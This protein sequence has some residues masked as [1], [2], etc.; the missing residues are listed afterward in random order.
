MRNVFTRLIATQPESD[1]HR[2]EDDEPVVS[3]ETLHLVAA[4]S[5]RVTAD[6]E[7]QRAEQRERFRDRVVRE[8]GD[9][10]AVVERLMQEAFGD[11]LCT[12]S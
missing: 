7:R 12:T 3:E 6:A 2:R 9:T 4:A 10:V 11:E 8:V 5:R 1:S